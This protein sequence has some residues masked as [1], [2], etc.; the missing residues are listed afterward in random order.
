MD[1]LKAEDALVAVERFQVGF[2]LLEKRQSAR[3]MRKWERRANKGKEPG[4]GLN[5]PTKQNL[6]SIGL[7]FNAI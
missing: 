5:K 3:I 6:A 1:R 7:G 4:D 2:G